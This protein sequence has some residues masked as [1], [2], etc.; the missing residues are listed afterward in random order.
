VIFNYKG[1]NYLIKDTISAK[2]DQNTHVYT[3]IVHPDQTF[4]VRIDGTTTKEGSL[5]EQWDFLPPKMIKDPEQSKPEDWVDEARID[6]PEDVKPEGYD[7]IPA[8]IEDPDAE[9]PEDWDEED[10]GEWEAPTIPNPEY[11]GPWKAQKISN[12]DYKG[13]WVHPEIENPDYFEDSEI[14]SYTSFGVVGLDVW[15]VKSGSVF[16]NIIVTDSVEEAEAFLAET[17]SKNIEKEKA[18]FDDIEEQKRAEME[19]EMEEED[20]PE[21]EFEM[22]E[23]DEE[24]EM[25]DEL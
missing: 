9:M 10:D 15:Q 11:N 1:E 3:L 2:T 12:P 18:M 22:P 20:F 16:D 5:T 8:V 19:A 6:D 21:E 24:V 7:D 14:Y 23:F 25:H 13:P 4:E 17:Y